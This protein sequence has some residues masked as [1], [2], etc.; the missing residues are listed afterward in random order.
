MAG[1]ARRRG[2]L[3]G[4]QLGIRLADVAGRQRDEAEDVAVVDLEGEVAAGDR[5]VEAL[6][7]EP[8]RLVRAAVVRGDQREAAQPPRREDVGAFASVALVR[9]L[10]APARRRPVAA[11]DLETGQRHEVERVVAAGPDLARI[12]RSV[13]SIARSTSSSWR[14]SP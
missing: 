11:E 12:S 4:G 14:A 13:I 2:A 1:P 8:P 6:G 10:G 5:E 9:G 3:G 7:R